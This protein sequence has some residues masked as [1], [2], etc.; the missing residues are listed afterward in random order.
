MAVSV[1]PANGSGKKQSRSIAFTVAQH[2]LE[3]RFK[4]AVLPDQ[5]NPCLDLDVVM[6][7]RRLYEIRYI[8]VRCPFVRF[9]VPFFLFHPFIDFTLL[10]GFRNIDADYCYFN[11]SRP[12]RMK[13]RPGNIFDLRLVLVQQSEQLFPLHRVGVPNRLRV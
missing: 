3:I 4:G 11:I 6:R 1:S 7:H 5:F 13:E 10:N 8:K 2:I 12:F 9:R